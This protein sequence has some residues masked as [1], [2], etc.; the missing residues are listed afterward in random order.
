[1]KVLVACEYSGI[2]RDEFIALGHDAMSCDLLPTE[3]PG[4]HYMGDVFDIINDGWD[5]MIAHPP[6]TYL[7]VSGMHWTT[8]GL[9]DP[10]L[11]EDALAFVQKLMDA[12][13][14]RIAVENPI[15]VISSRIR[16]PNQIIQ[17]WWFGDD[18]S[19]KTCLWLKNLPPLKIDPLKVCAPQGWGRMVGRSGYVGVRV[20]RGAFLPG[21]QRALRRLRVHRPDRGRCRDQGGGWRLV[22]NPCSP[23]TKDAVGKPDAERAEQNRPLAGSLERAQPHLPRHRCGVCRTM[24]HLT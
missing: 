13:I 19:K 5:L 3:K 17:P 11:T 20:L 18:A 22:R 12:P 15:S 2:V 24:E 6:C 8:R 7:S 14:E 21:V 9:R 23:P 10:Q 4:P 1:M 16:K